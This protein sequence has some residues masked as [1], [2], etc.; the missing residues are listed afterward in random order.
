MPN[1]EYLK[2]YAQNLLASGALTVADGEPK[3]LITMTGWRASDPWQP[4]RWISDQLEREDRFVGLLTP[5][6]DA[7]H[8]TGW[9]GIDPACLS[10]SA[11]KR[12]G[13]DV[14]D[15]LQDLFDLID[16]E[17]ARRSPQPPAVSIGWADT[18]HF[19]FLA[20]GADPDAARA[21]V[22]RAW[23]AHVKVTCAD[24]DYLRPSEVSVLTGPLG[25]AWRDFSE[26][27]RKG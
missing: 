13:R 24:P 12:F 18:G 19:K 21:A 27:P 2:T 8:D 22:M 6:W 11:R 14:F 3:W 16:A 4:G 10:T 17:W 7:D 25:Q 9:Q 1:C 23:Q 26:F 5:F 20:V 15:R